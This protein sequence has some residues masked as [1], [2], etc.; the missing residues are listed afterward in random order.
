MRHIRE[1]FSMEIMED[2][3]NPVL[4]E[5]RRSLEHWKGVASV[6]SNHDPE[7]SKAVYSGVFERERYKCV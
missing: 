5:A 3:V 6:A 2:M 4:N 1:L 7:T